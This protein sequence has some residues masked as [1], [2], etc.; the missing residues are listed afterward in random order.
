MEGM[1]SAGAQIIVLEIKHVD[2]LFFVRF[3]LF[4]EKYPCLVVV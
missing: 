4:A 3:R 2:T 1:A